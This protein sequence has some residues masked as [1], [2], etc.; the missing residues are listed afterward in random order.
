M[1]WSFNSFA[2]VHA[3][4]PDILDRIEQA[5]FDGVGLAASHFA[6]AP[7]NLGGLACSGVYVF[8]ADRERAAEGALEDLLT[9]TQ[10]LA[11]VIVIPTSS[12][13]GT[14]QQF[15]DMLA[16][17]LER[18]EG[19]ICLEPLC[20]ALSQISA[21]RSVPDAIQILEM[22]P[23]SRA[24][25]VL[26]VAHVEWPEL[27]NLPEEIIARCEILH[28]SD[29]ATMGCTLDPRL[30]PGDGILPL[31]ALRRRLE[32]LGFDGWWEFEVLDNPSGADP[33][34]CMAARSALLA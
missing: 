32:S 4:A 15:G 2:A 14:L 33:A 1:K 22:L 30:M 11:P 25:L 31:V 13:E 10:A 18:V 21:L 29:R 17:V 19:R 5:G 6:E 7:A 24:G 20:S 8:F 34:A 28:V 26:D 23:R 16:G 3:R 12:W 9:R 27:M